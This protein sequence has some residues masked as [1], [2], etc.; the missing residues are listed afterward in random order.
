MGGGGTYQV[1]QL[2]AHLRR[3]LI[4]QKR[5]I[6]VPIDGHVLDLDQLHQ[7]KIKIKIKINA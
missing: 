7:K 1:I 5:G 4:A 6:R 2:F 3:R